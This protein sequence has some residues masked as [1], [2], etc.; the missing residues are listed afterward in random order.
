VSTVKKAVEPPSAQ[1][2]NLHL[3][4]FRETVMLSAIDHILPSMGKVR[5]SKLEKF[6]DDLLRIAVYVSELR[7]DLAFAQ[8]AEKPVRT[9]RVKLGRARRKIEHSLNYLRE[10]EVIAIGMK[11]ELTPGQLDFQSAQRALE[12]LKTKLGQLEATAAALIH[13]NLRRTGEDTLASQTPYKLT[14]LDLKATPGSSA[15]MHRAVELLDEVIEK[16][17]RGKVPPH[18]VDEFISE[19]LN[20]LG[21]QGVNPANVKTIRRRFRDRKARLLAESSTSYT[22]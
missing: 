11:E 2:P 14:P 20:P 13:P 19:Y 3:D 16:F 6:G 7:D 12:S 22:P 9:T 15:V 17:T 4:K 5:E 8:G 10:A 18:H 1:K 21:W